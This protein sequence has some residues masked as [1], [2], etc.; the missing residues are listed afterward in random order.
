MPVPN[1]RAERGG[2][3]Q[4]KQR[5]PSALLGLRSVAERLLCAGLLAWAVIS[6]ESWAI[7]PNTPFTNLAT[8]S[9]Q[10][11]GT[12]YSVSAGST[13]ITD[14]AA[15]NSA[16]YGAAVDPADIDEN[17][18]GAIGLLSAF[19]LDPADSHTF[20][21]SDPNFEIVGNELRLATGFTLDF[22]A[23]PLTTVAVLVTDSAGAS[24]LVNLSITVNDLNEAP[25]ALTLSSTGFDASTP[26]A[27]VGTLVV[28][29]PDSGDS[30]SFGVDDSR[31][32][33]VGSMLKLLDTESLPL[34]TSV[35]VTVTATDSGGLTFM[36]TF[37]LTA[38]PPG[39]GA[40]GDATLVLLQASAPGA[41]AGS[42]TVG[43]AQCDAGAGYSDLPIPVTFTGTTLTVPGS[44]DLRTGSLFKSGDPIFID[45]MDQDADLD[46][47]LIDTVEVQV[48][49]SDGDSE[50]LRLAETGPGSAR[51]VGYLQTGPGAS[52]AGDC[53]L[54]A[55]VNVSFT[56]SYVDAFNPG[57]LAS[58]AGVINPLSRV[59]LATTGQAV[60]STR[61]EL[62]DST[63]GAPASVTGETAG[64]AFPAAV[65]SGETAIDALGNQYGFPAGTY[66]FPAV[67]AGAYRLLVTPPN[68]FRFP[69]TLPDSALQA[70]PGA[71]YRLS[72]G[73]RGAVF[74]VTGPA[75][76]VDVPLDLAPLVPTP[77]ALEVLT[78]APGTTGASSLY[79][80]PTQCFD[81]SAFTP[82]PMPVDRL[83]TAITVPGTQP[84]LEA[85]RFNRGDTIFL[86]VNDPDQDLDP[87]APDWIEVVVTAADGDRE[88]VR[89]QETAASSGIFSGYL[90]TSRVAGASSDCSLN[91]AAGS[92]AVIGY[93]DPDDG[94]DA[95][96]FTA[97]LDPGF[98]TFSSSNGAPVDGVQVTLLDAVTG[99]PAQ[100][101]TFAGDGVTPFPTTVT[102]GGTATDAAG[103]SITFAPGSFYFP[104]LLPGNYRFEVSAPI[105]YRFPSVRE[106][107][108]L[109]ALPGGPYQL[110]AGSRGDA[111]T[112]AAGQ[113]FEF[114]L[115][116]D[117]LTVDVFVSKQASRDVVGIGDLLQYQ[118]LVQ[119][120]EAVVQS[121][122]SVVDEL[123]YGFR[124][125]AGS[126]QINGA[127][128][129]D[130]Q[131]SGDGRTLRFTDVAFD[132]AS[133]AVKYVVEV[134]IGAKLGRA[135]NSASATGMAIG[136]SNTAFAD[137]TVREDLL[138]SKAILI[139]QIYDGACDAGADR[140]G[141]AGVRVWLED[142]TYVVTDAEGK[143]H[144]EGVTPGTHVVQ[145]DEASLPETHELIACE[146]NTRFAGSVRSQFVD[147]AA[148]S[149]WR[150]DFHTRPKAPAESLLRAQLFARLEAETVMHR[151]VVAGGSVPVQAL[152]AVVM[153]PTGARY[154]PGS[155]ALD[156]ASLADPS[157]AD[158]GALTIR[159]GERTAAFENNLVFETRVDAGVESLSTKAMLMFETPADGKQKTPV[160]ITELALNWP[161]S[162]AEP[163]GEVL[164]GG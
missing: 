146:Q 61:L 108:E 49:T 9:Y 21:T 90:Q 17:T 88:R 111:F 64:V 159:L 113:S 2:R 161:D 51:F 75:F 35:T 114:D 94:S 144:I 74:T 160:L 87:F 92:S 29:D 133:A 117:P 52:V 164:E 120:P 30:H 142:G 68:R 105:E 110:A 63:S 1:T 31:F 7:P 134:T 41:G 57:D 76:G 70:L 104:Y 11:G 80:S 66:R 65:F 101:R 56:V 84:L 73:S 8:A 131:I 22:E 43:T 13:L 25:T 130:P 138:Q 148:G 143:Y 38:T 83:G 44:I 12:D 62:L 85:G 157:G 82:A 162:L 102:S 156:G 53:A 147:V 34:G 81:G 48:L 112:V 99:L 14:P 5:P 33:I 140:Q 32:E 71:P 136:S 67:A 107:A 4:R 86:R 18:A 98:T 19:D 60:D 121:T 149:M 124:Y 109:D 135:R 10:V 20:S 58:T 154:V 126:A 36:Q 118:V 28:S 42:V 78:L 26:G 15:G 116:L 151:L 123:P 89:L 93:T 106:D 24:R 72:P 100:G 3:T 77:A 55:A 6:G 79:V 69:S 158:S 137:V 39:G 96:A 37:T 46:S 16:P 59:F 152:T 97:L 47:G 129:A 153:L 119:D 23:T 115:P 128:A 139:G 127:A 132:N 163:N 45:V 122:F 141:L 155:L 40:P 95:I 91:T 103:V 54:G 150:A 145:V 27:P 125:V 50:L